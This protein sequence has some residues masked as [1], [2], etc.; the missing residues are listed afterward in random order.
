MNIVQDSSRTRMHEQGNKMGSLLVNDVDL[1]AVREIGNRISERD[2]VAPSTQRKLLECCNTEQAQITLLW[3]I[4]VE[5]E[6]AIQWVI[7]DMKVVDDSRRIAIEYERARLQKMRGETLSLGSIEGEQLV[8]ETTA[9]LAGVNEDTTF[10][11]PA[12]P[13]KGA[14]SS[15]G[16]TDLIF[17]PGDGA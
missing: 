4:V 10:S 8:R 6:I 17:N 12:E 1:A 11:S 2:L 5:R 9:F 3:Y 7:V 13:P 16:T 14:E 15:K